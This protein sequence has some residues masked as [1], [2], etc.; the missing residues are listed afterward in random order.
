LP[1]HLYERA[2]FAQMPLAIAAIASAVMKRGNG[3]GEWVAVR[4]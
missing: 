1:T 4:R 3:I 2:N